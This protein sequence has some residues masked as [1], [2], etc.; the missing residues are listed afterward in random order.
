MIRM[1]RPAAAD[2]VVAVFRIPRKNRMCIFLIFNL[3]Q[4]GKNGFPDLD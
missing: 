1:S 4:I 3:T 2:A